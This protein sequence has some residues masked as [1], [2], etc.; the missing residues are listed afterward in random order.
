MRPVGGAFDH[1]IAPGITLSN[2][3]YSALSVLDSCVHRLSQVCPYKALLKTMSAVWHIITVLR[4]CAITHMTT[5]KTE[6]D[7]T[8]H[9]HEN[10]ALF[11]LY[12]IYTTFAVNSK[13]EHTSPQRYFIV[14][15]SMFTQI[16]CTDSLKPLVQT[17]TYTDPLGLTGRFQWPLIT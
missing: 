8:S 2:G 14:T 5:I 13:N 4:A 9:Y 7:N 12:N 11:V 3:F 1:N 6:T 16:I 17:H 15:H 10:V